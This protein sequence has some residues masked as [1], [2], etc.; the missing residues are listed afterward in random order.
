MKAGDTEPTTP[1]L[2]AVVYCRATNCRVPKAAPPM[3][4]RNTIT[5]ALALSFGRSA[6]ICGQAMTLTTRN[7]STQRSNETVAG[8]ACPAIARAT[9]WLP[10]QQA[11]ASGNRR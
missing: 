1:M 4:D 8:G 11:A 3:S 6:R 7:T 5:P 10:A 2:R 9:T